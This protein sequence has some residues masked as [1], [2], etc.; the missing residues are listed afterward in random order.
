M[1]L[2]MTDLTSF[3]PG[4]DNTRGFTWLGPDMKQPYYVQTQVLRDRNLLG[5]LERLRTELREM[6]EKEDELNCMIK[7]QHDQMFLGRHVPDQPNPVAGGSGPD[8]NIENNPWDE[9]EEEEVEEEEEEEEGEEEEDVYGYGLGPESDSQPEPESD[10]QS[11]PE[12]EAEAVFVR[13]VRGRGPPPGMPGGRAPVHFGRGRG[14]PPGMPGGP[15]PV[16]FGRGRG[17]PPGMPGG[18][19]PVRF[20][21]GRGPPPGMPGGRA[22]VWAFGGRN[23]EPIRNNLP[24]SN[25][26][27]IRD[28]DGLACAVDAQN[29]PVRRHRELI[30]THVYR[31]REESEAL[32]RELADLQTSYSYY[33]DYTVRFPIRIFSMGH[34]IQLTQNVLLENAYF[35][36]RLK[37]A[38]FL[39]QIRIHERNIV[40]LTRSAQV[41]FAQW[42]EDRSRIYWVRTDASGHLQEEEEELQPEW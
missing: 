37:E 23:N 1:N 6:K 27:P 38:L 19:P 10:P 42:P 22:P 5:V 2:I 9:V 24:I 14:P 16:R 21:R 30:R 18:P 3:P 32:D 31:T 41:P 34:L 39:R 35:L 25:N 12:S 28:F 7:F 33:P 17:P 40:R 15:P 11:E 13:T 29:Y 36:H 20:G 8:Q 26:D 4:L